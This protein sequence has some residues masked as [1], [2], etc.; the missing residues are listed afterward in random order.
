M[1][2]IE[3]STRHCGCWCLQK[4][5]SDH[6]FFCENWRIPE[7]WA[8]FEKNLR[9]FL[10][11]S[12]HF[13]TQI[14]AYFR[15]ISREFGWNSRLCETFWAENSWVSVTRKTC[16]KLCCWK[17]SNLNWKPLMCTIINNRTMCVPQSILMNRNLKNTLKVQNMRIA[18]ICLF[19]MSTYR[20]WTEMADLPQVLFYMS[21]V[22]QMVDQPAARKFVIVDD[23]SACDVCL[24]LQSATINLA[25]L[26]L[27][28]QV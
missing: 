25:H 1:H 6:V 20:E 12:H 16:Y 2:Q 7:F 9:C 26:I 27:T 17:F 4:C 3:R 28:F 5:I 22:P 11:I 8:V 13:S 21:F 23:S 10:G 19:T 14:A 18:Y 24:P 15:P